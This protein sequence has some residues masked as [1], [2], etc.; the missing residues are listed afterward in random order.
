MEVCSL[1]CRK[2]EQETRGNLHTAREQRNNEKKARLQCG[3]HQKTTTHTP[4][5]SLVS[6]PS[7]TPPR[8]S[9][10]RISH[11][12]WVLYGIPIS[13]AQTEQLV[14]MEATRRST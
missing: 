10:L 7:P 1:L 3:A 8:P 11:I 5:E 4:P 6:L 14:G 9:R 13:E 12:T 2:G